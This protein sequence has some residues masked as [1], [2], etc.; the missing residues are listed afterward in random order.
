LSSVGGKGRADAATPHG[1]KGGGG[2]Q[3]FNRSCAGNGC[4]G[5]GNTPCRVLLQRGATAAPCVADSNAAGDPA[6]WQHISAGFDGQG[7]G[8][9]RVKRH[10]L[11]HWHRGPHMSWSGSATGRMDC[12]FVKL[13]GLVGLY[14]DAT[15]NRIF[16]SSMAACA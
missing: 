12:S 2:P 13:C 10:G 7:D 4:G 3:M 15:D 11:R 8:A 16:S 6:A 9:G 5:S 14:G 1:W